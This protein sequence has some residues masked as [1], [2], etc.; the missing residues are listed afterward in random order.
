MSHF[1]NIFQCVED[2]SDMVSEF[3]KLKD[4]YIPEFERKSIKTED[5]E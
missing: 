1:R 4:E 5:Q 3:Q 2:W